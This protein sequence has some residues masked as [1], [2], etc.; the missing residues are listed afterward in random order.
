M[1]R[2]ALL[3]ARLE[4]STAAP[5]LA[6]VAYIKSIQMKVLVGPDSSREIVLNS[7]PVTFFS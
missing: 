2:V 4:P 3:L 5:K 1:S 7:A 6:M